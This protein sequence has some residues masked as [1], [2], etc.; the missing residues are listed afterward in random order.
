MRVIC[1]FAVDPSVKS[2]GSSYEINRNE[3]RPKMPFVTDQC[4][5][6]ELIEFSS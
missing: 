3:P 1:C 5:F 6:P 2:D 4:N